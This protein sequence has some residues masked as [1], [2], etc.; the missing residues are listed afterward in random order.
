ML[1]VDGLAPFAGVN[2]LSFDVPAGRCAGL[3]SSDVHALLAIAECTCGIRIPFAGRVLIDDLDVAR[4]RDRTQPQIAAG[5]ARAAH[6]LTS[7]G[8]H[9]AAVSASRRTRMPVTEGLARLGLDARTRL[10]TG[11]AKSAAALLAALLPAAPVVILHDPFRN[12]DDATRAKSIDWI[13]ALSESSVSV[14]VTGTEERDVRAV[15]HSVIEFGA[16]R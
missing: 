2:P 8:E 9:A 4:Q 12:L 5:L 13:R 1:R 7:L 10:N 6:H 15:S 3:L 16:S 11:P 14:L